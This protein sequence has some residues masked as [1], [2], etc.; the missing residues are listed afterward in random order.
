MIAKIRAFGG[1]SGARR[2][3]GSSIM[4]RRG[5]VGGRVSLPTGLPAVFLLSAVSLVGCPIY[6]HEREGCFSTRDCAPGYVCD[7]DTAEC[8]APESDECSRPSDCGVNETCDKNGQC[9]LG[10][11]SFA[12]I[13]CVAGYECS[14]T[15][16]AWRCVPEGSAAGG[17]GAGGEASGSGGA[18]SGGQGGAGSGGR[19]EP[20]LGGFGGEVSS[21]G[22]PGSSGGQ[23]G[24]SGAGGEPA[25][26]GNVSSAGAGGV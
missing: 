14:N 26:G 7:R 25:A 19:A 1:L 8:V 15:D 21:A 17:S 2:L 16:G 11:C 6:D 3:L 24:S 4:K 10:D 22:Q 20:P 5:L 18:V 12:D 9:R 23:P 13:G